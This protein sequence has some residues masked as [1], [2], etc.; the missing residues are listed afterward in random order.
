[1]LTEESERIEMSRRERDQ[2]KVLYGMLQASHEVR[3]LPC[4]TL[5]QDRA[6]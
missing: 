2:L 1:M 5:F 3:L 6:R 4:P